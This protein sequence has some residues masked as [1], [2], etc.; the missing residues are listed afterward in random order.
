MYVPLN[1][2]WGAARA[3]GRDMARGLTRFDPEAL[4]SLRLSHGKRANRPHPLTAEAL[5]A[6]VGASKSQILDYEQGRHT[7]DPKRI[8]ALAAALDVTPEQLMLTEGRE[9]W[10]VA[11]VRR[12]GGLRAQD[13]YSALGVSP[14]SYRRF[15]AGGIVP[16]RSPRFLDDTAAALDISYSD[17]DRAVNNIAAVRFRRRRSLELV[18]RLAEI[19]VY[20]PGSW[21]G[22]GV[23]DDEIVELASLYGRPPQRI[24]RLLTHSLE[25]L[26]HKYLRMRR[27]EVIAQYDPDAARQQRAVSAFETWNE[28]FQRELLL[29]PD[30]MERF[31]RSA[32]P[33]EA[34][35][36]LVDLSE[37]DAYA[38][39]GPWVLAALLGS[40]NAALSLPPS[41]VHQREFRGLPG[42]QLSHSGRDHV[43]RFTG[44]YSALYPTL[45][46]PRTPA[47]GSSAARPLRLGLA[48]G[49]DA[50]KDRFVIPPHSLDMLIKRA[51]G[52]GRVILHPGPST[53]LLISLPMSLNAGPTRQPVTIDV[54]PSE[55]TH[56][57]G[58]I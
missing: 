19:Y 37:S 11:D 54:T 43:R 25:E 50:R 4:R 28:I 17:L 24:R 58:E 1:Q 34:W 29:I 16:A 33:S 12:A 22:P 47:R 41:L 30:L 8:Q 48:Q 40:P 9:A 14:K 51:D 46:R 39:D 18:W 3:R 38:P 13:I 36:A 23:D 35:Q 20:P 44:F 26:R 49:N 57:I 55:P 6:M 5:G 31:H 42:L 7:P 27:E 10:D 53:K 52:S 32:Q 15:E 56:D 21:A 2:S 45:R